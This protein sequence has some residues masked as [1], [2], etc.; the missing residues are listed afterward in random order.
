MAKIRQLGGFRDLRSFQTA[1][2][3][4]DATQ[5]FCERFI[6]YKS[7]TRDQ[8]VQAARSGRQNIA[9]GSRAAPASSQT[10]LCP[11]N[12]ARAS[13]EELLLDY[14]DYLRQHNHERWP[15]DSPEAMAVRNA[16]R[17]LRASDR[18][19]PSDPSDQSDRSDPSDQAKPY[20]QPHEDARRYAAY[21]QWL[22]HDDPAVRANALICLINQANM[23][24]D[25]QIAA[26]EK[27]FIKQGGYSEALATARIAERTRQR[28]DGNDNAP[29]CPKCGCVMVLRT[30]RKGPR[31]GSQFWGC[32]GFPECREARNL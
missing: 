31:Q 10:E 2:L 30:A 18:S 9:Q 19:D 16:Y 15:P 21:A 22:D 26:L 13:L 1:T 24:L 28:Q 17:A 20:D 29:A 7:R 6:D 3:I 14:E 11:V 4:F 8:M 5:K 25:R 23:L 32:S 12:V 27:Q